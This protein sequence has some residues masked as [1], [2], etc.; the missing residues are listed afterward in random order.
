MTNRAALKPT[1]RQF[2]SVGNLGQAAAAVVAEELGMSRE[3]VQQL[4]LARGNKIKAEFMEILKQYGLPVN[5][6]E[7]ELVKQA[8]FY[9]NGFAMPTLE[10]QAERIERVLGI[11]LKWP[12][13]AQSMSFTTGEF[14][15]DGVA[16]WPTLGALGELW[17]ISDPR[18][19]GYGKVIAATCNAINRSSDMVPLVNYR[20]GQLDDRYVRIHAGVMSK[21]A[22]LE[23]EA[24]R[25]GLNALVM[26]V[27][28][29]DWQTGYCYSP[30]NARWQCINSNRLAIE[31]V[32]GLSLLTGINER[33]TAYGHMFCDFTGAEYNWFADGGWSCSLVVDFRGGGFEFSAGGADYADGNYGAFVGFPGVLELAA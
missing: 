28:L 20:D 33:L 12:D 4:W 8:W 21:L 5:P 11:E 23:D 10:V 19:R 30:R 26:P 27:N 3:Q 16:L 17:N 25:Q 18:V 2:S 29:G 15:A 32:A 14:G 13:E 1:V 24:E 9:P 6:Y 31:P 22:F 7:T